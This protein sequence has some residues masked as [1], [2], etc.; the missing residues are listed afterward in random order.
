MR[1]SSL[2]AI[3]HPLPLPNL[4]SLWI[5]DC[6]L[7]RINADAFTT[8]TALTTLHISGN[9]L[10]TIVLTPALRPLAQQLRQLWVNSNKLTTLE[11]VKGFTKLKSL[12]ACGNGIERVGEVVAGTPHT[13]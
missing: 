6:S 13:P 10:T 7:Q 1:Q 9:A 3:D 5:T 4:E 11:C 2:T 12:W 8:T